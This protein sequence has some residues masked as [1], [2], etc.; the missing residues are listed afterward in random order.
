MDDLQAL[1]GGLFQLKGDS[2]ED[3]ELERVANAITDE[4]KRTLRLALPRSVTDGRKIF[5][6]TCFIQPSHLP[7][8]FLAQGF[9]PLIVY[10]EETDAVMI[11]PANYWPEELFESWAGGEDD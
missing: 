8:G 3:E 7:D 5:F 6:T 10:P 9:F 2:P 1:A 11:L 4:L